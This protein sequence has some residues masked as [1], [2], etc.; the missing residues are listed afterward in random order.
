MGP[1]RDVARVHFDTVL[2]TGPILRSTGYC[3][4]M[5]DRWPLYYDSNHPSLYLNEI[6]QP[7]IQDDIS[8][9]LSK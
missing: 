6:M 2:L 5:Y 9:F 8:A 7:V 1:I 4:I 3:A